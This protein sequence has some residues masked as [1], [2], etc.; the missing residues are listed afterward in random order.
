M[1][2]FSF[3]Y[4]LPNNETCYIEY[5]QNRHIVTIDNIMCP[6]TRYFTLN[7]QDKDDVIEHLFE[8]YTPDKSEG[9]ILGKREALE[10]IIED[11]LSK[12]QEKID[13][14][15]E[16]MIDIYWEQNPKGFKY[17]YTVKYEEKVNMITIEYKNFFC[18]NHQRLKENEEEAINSIIRFYKKYGNTVTK[19]MAV[20]EIRKIYDVIDAAYDKKYQEE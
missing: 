18:D 16:N 6:L 20:E 1:I 10:G 14:I 5:E 11:I 4:I 19:E 13:E 15:Y 2:E 9:F 8:K 17:K 3:Y 7:D 12:V